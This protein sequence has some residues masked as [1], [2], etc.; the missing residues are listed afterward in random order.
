MKTLGSRIKYFRERLGLSQIGL[1]E[2]TGVSQASIAR[3]E[4]G[5]QKNLKTETMRKLAAGLDVSL[6]QLME[7]FMM[8]K[9]EKASYN[10]TRTIPVVRARDFRSI[11]DINTLARKADTFEPSLSADRNAFYLEVTSDLM[12]GPVIEVGD[13]ILIEPSAEIKEG[14]MV[15]YLS[16]EKR[17]LGKIYYRLN[18][19]LIQPLNPD[20]PP[21]MFKKRDKVK[22]RIGIFRIREIRK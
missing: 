12:S 22:H 9:E 3:I 20:I 7:P 5:I 1:S 10:E 19:V 17:C 4:L 8:V 6:A 18:D 13:M 2:K 11:Q 14:D 21:I 15:F 16:P